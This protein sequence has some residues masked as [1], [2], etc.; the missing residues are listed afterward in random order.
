MLVQDRVLTNM[1][2]PPPCS[3]PISK[4]GCQ[5]TSPQVDPLK[6]PLGHLDACLLSTTHP[7]W[8]V[9][10]GWAGAVPI[11]A[12]SPLPLDY[13]MQWLGSEAGSTHHP[14]G[15]QAKTKGYLLLGSHLTRHFRISCA[16]E[17]SWL[18]QPVGEQLRWLKRTWGRE[19][20]AW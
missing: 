5:N 7:L 20:G 13:K 9:V 8:G 18:P 11:P 19:E 3:R 4:D 17:G 14:C 15:R 16:M 10:W 6:E 2:H 1:S 12:C